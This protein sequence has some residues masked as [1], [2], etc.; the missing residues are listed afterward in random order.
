MAVHKPPM[1]PP[2]IAI[3]RGLGAVVVD[4]MSVELMENLK[5]IK[6]SNVCLASSSI[7]MVFEGYSE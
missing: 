5:R 3:L 6:N 7:Y 1:P 2:M 4:D